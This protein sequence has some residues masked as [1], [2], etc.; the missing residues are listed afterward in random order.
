MV[1]ITHNIS[2]AQDVA[3]FCVILH[4]GKAI[5]KTMA[6][7]NERSRGVVVMRARTSSL[8]ER[9]TVLQSIP[10]NLR[11]NQYFEEQRFRL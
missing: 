2:A 6:E 1:V 10:I 4:A 11:S 3:R 5:S 8:R 7:L 9:R